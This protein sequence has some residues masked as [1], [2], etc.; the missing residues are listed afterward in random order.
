MNMEFE[1]AICSQTTLKMMTLFGLK[2]GVGGEPGDMVQSIKVILDLDHHYP[3]VEIV[4][5]IDN[6][7]IKKV[8]QLM[9]EAKIMEDV[10]V[11]ES[12]HHYEFKAKVRNE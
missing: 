12:T 8:Y 2:P 11:I 7:L 4:R 6:E 9:D 5:L 10:P 1:S 3:Y